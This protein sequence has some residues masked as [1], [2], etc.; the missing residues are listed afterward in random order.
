MFWRRCAYLLAVLSLAAA[1]VLSG[2]ALFALLAAAYLALAV[3]ALIAL[4]IAARRLRVQI[5]LPESSARNAEF[6]AR[7][8][9]SGSALLRCMHFR[10]RFT[11]INL[12][13]GD[14]LAFEMRSPEEEL[15][16]FS[17]HCG[18]LRIQIERANI[19]D[20]LNLFQRRLRLQESASTLIL[21]DAF[22]IA[23]ELASPDLPNPD[24]GDYSPDRPG[25]DPSE[26]FGI[27]DYREGDALKSIHWKLSEK[28]DRTVVREASLPVARSILL[29]LD[30]CPKAA[31]DPDDVCAACEALIS[32]SL[33]LADAGVPH[34]IA[35]L[36]RELGILEARDIAQP[37]DL[38]GE[39]GALLAARCAPDSN[40]LL[41]HLAEQEIPEYSRLLIFAAAPTEGFAALDN[42]ATLLLPKSDS[43]NAVCCLREALTH[44][45][46]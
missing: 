4:Q 2:N 12:L 35:W 8:S 46:V 3:G 1:A 30:N 10:L 26:L 22:E 11:A 19:A 43:E 9:L 42:R 45:T 36:N 20:P 31:V 16:L 41:S 13:C 27:R 15:A 23:V 18:R 32:C 28:Y 29:L 5:E 25:G 38:Y 39:Q 34:R 17:P 40:G 21:P 14:S 24:S 44:L 33:A 7:I 37:D 6:T